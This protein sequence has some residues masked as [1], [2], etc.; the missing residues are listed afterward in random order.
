MSIQCIDKNKKYVVLAHYRNELGQPRTLRRIIYGTEKDAIRKEAVLLDELKNGISKETRF[1]ELFQDYLKTRTHVK[2]NTVTKEKEIYNTFLAVF[3]KKKLSLITPK[4]IEVL[5][6]SIEK[7]EGS[8]TQKNKAIFL[9][10][11]IFKFGV[12]AYGIN[13]PTLYLTSFSKKVA[14]KIQYFTYTP[15]EFNYVL[16][17]VTG[18][19]YKVLYSI[20]YWCGLRRGEALA[21]TPRDVLLETHELSINK[22]VNSKKELGTPKNTASYRNVKMH[23]ALFDKVLPYATSKNKNLLGGARILPPSTVNGRFTR[24]IQRANKKR[25]ADGLEPL[26]HL[27][28]H[29]LRHSHATFLASKGMPIATVSARLGHSN[30]NETMNTYMHLFKGDDERVVDMLDNY[31]SAD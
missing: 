10:K 31:N 4:D 20:Y 23:Q 11:R 6:Q 2:E 24:A 14:N 16:N 19:N 1:I 5:R 15:E 13:N 21:L 3:S 12:K 27:R 8:I 30:I 25:V 7:H 9:I 22:S 29:D 18:D 26:P 28:V 17:F